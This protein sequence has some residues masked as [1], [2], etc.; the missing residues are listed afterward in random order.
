MSVQPFAL[1]LGR[2]GGQLWSPAQ[3]SLV[4]GK[5]VGAL[6]EVGEGAGAGMVAV[7]QLESKL[8]GGVHKNWMTFMK[9]GYCQLF[10]L[11]LEE[12][13]DCG[14]LSELIANTHTTRHLVW[15]LLVTSVLILTLQ[16]SSEYRSLYCTM[17]P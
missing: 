17:H 6:V 2:E 13:Q 9:L 7:V 11:V 15:L 3:P 1:C 5:D 14:N 4:L 8:S 10:V 12:I 16:M